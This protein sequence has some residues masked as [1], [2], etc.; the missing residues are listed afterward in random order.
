LNNELL[1]NSSAVVQ[2]HVSIASSSI[3][4]AASK[5]SIMPVDAKMTSVVFASKML[6]LGG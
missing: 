2:L 3:F 1:Q 5:T 4:L 6:D